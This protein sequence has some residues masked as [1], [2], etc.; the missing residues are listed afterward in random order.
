M[1][2]RIHFIGIGGIGVSALA[3][4]YLEKGHRVSGSDLAS[5][6]I[7][8]ALKKNGARII[9]GPHKKENFPKTADL[10]IY[11]PAVQKSNPELKQAYQIQNTKYNIQVLSYPEALGELTR[12]YFTIA[13]SGTHGKSTTTAMLSLILIKAGLNP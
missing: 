7:T 6:E 2:C 11:S 13:V 12:Q 1:R 10:V 5:S 8:E 3:R 9:I 4:Y